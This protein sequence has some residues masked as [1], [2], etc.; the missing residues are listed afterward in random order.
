MKNCSK[1]Y[2]RQLI[3]RRLNPLLL[4]IHQ[5]PMYHDLAQTELGEIHL[6][7]DSRGLCDGVFKA[8]REGVSGIVGESLPFSCLL[9]ILL[10]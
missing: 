1:S 2:E 4:L 6:W 10:D 3:T 5:S 9:L 7:V 8:H